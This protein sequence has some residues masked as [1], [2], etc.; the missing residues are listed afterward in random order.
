M[1]RFS[2]VRFLILVVAVSGILLIGL[3]MALPHGEPWQITFR[4]NDAGHIDIHIK[5]RS[6]K[7]DDVVVKTNTAVPANFRDTEVVIRR[8]FKLPVGKVVFSDLTTLPGRVTFD[9]DAH[10]IDIME[11]GIVLDGKDI[12]WQQAMEKAV[13]L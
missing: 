1:K 9:I 2:Y 7:I 6:L 8:G 12:T 3:R 11:R 13:S 10:S 5:N 4:A